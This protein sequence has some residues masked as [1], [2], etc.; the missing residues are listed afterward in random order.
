[1]FKY[2]DQSPVGIARVNPKYPHIQ[3]EIGSNRELHEI[4]LTIR[5]ILTDLEGT[6]EMS[7]SGITPKILTFEYYAKNKKT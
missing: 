4:G 3:P 1:M 5:N 6:P 7:F 2:R